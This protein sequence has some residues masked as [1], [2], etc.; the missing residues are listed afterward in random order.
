MTASDAD[1]CVVLTQVLKRGRRLRVLHEELRVLQR[2]RSWT[3]E[4]VCGESTAGQPSGAERLE[5]RETP[6][7]A[8]MKSWGTM[9]SVEK[10]RCLLVDR[11]RQVTGVG[12]PLAGILTSI[13]LPGLRRTGREHVSAVALAKVEA[14]FL[15]YA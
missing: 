9:V 1:S 11:S 4:A 13:L 3:P 10:S 6:A 15:Q 12:S 7:Q 2:Q 8:R 5:L 14:R